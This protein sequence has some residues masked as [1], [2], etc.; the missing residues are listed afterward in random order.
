[1]NNI[2]VDTG[3][4][5]AYLGTKDS[6]QEKAIEIYNKYINSG[7]NNILV[8]YPVLYETINTKLLRDKNKKAADWFL[9]KLV[10]DPKFVRVPDKNYREAAFNS[11]IGPTRERGISLVDNVLRI[12][13]DDELLKIDALITFNTGDFVDICKK[14]GVLLIDQF[15]INDK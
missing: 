13:V 1:M 15:Y 12:M 14:R 10:S 2:L 5:Y 11:T 8:P 7:I 4:W 6:L 9:K 3:F